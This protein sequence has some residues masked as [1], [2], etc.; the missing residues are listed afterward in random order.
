MMSLEPS[1]LPW[2]SVPPGLSVK[3]LHFS[4]RFLTRALRGEAVPFGDEVLEA[5]DIRAVGG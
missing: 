1:F 2:I 3:N 4:Y 5:P